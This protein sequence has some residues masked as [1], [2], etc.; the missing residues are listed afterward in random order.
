MGAFKIMIVLMLFYSFA[1]TSLTYA[2]PD[3][4][5]NY[6]TSFS[7]DDTTNLQ[8]VSDEI[9]GSLEQQTNIPV[10]EVGALVFYSGNIIVDLLLNFL[11]AI[12]QM[13]GFLISGF[14]LLFNLD[15][16]L[17]VYFETFLI[18]LFTGMYALGLIQLVAGVR[19]G[20]II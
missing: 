4:A 20:R 13:F 2:I 19:S 14:T 18:V 3:G 10:I 8:T 15:G 17:V 9:Q 12:P 7:N 5:K 16:Q 6:V 1:I 11:Y